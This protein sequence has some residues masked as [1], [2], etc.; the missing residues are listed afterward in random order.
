MSTTHKVVKVSYWSNDVFLVPK[1]INLEDT[2][3]VKFWGV[4]YNE[5]HIVLV[6][7]K[8]FS[9]DSQGWLEN[10]DYKYPDGDA[11]ILDADELDIDKEE[12][13][14]NEVDINE[15]TKNKA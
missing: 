9:I 10:A 3:Q 7:G 4:K 13:G 12:K 6:N 15:D 11:E 2:K 5:L 14:F 8:E 1:N